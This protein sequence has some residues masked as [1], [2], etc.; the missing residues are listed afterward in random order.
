MPSTSIHTR[1][2]SV[3]TSFEVLDAQPRDVLTI[4][5]SGRDVYLCCGTVG[6]ENATDALSFKLPAGSALEM[7]PAP[8][9][10]IYIRASVAGD[11]SY[12]FS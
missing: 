11:V 10:E 4:H 5:A 7:L 8:K 9:G 1:T 2:M 6:V 3:G 12:W